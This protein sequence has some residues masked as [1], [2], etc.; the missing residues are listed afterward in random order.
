[1]HV[2][3]LVL[4]VLLTAALGEA[5]WDGKCTKNGKC[6]HLFMKFSCDRGT[7]CKGAEGR[8]CKIDGIVPAYY[9]ECPIQV[10]PEPY[11]DEVAEEND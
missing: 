10:E 4:T 2:K 11:G 1:M 9:V 7:S 3:A 6:K 8:P 5:R